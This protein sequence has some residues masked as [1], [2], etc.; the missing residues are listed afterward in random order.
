M[1][2]GP[3]DS[4]LSSPFPP[5]HLS[6]NE[7][8]TIIHKI[9]ELL[10]ESL[11]DYEQF[12]LRDR[13]TVSELEWKP[14]TK[15]HGLSAYRKRHVIPRESDSSKVH[16]VL[17]VGEIEGTVEDVMLG[18]VHASS[19]LTAVFE[20]FLY[21]SA[22][23]GCATLCS[24]IKP[25][26]DSPDRM[27]RISWDSLGSLSS[28]L[29]SVMKPRDFVM[30]MASGVTTNSTGE[31]IAYVFSHSVDV[32]N[33]PPTP[34]AIRA[35]RHFT[36]LYRQVS[37]G[38]MHLYVVGR[39]DPKGRILTRVAVRVST[40][41]ALEIAPGFISF[42]AIKKRT[43]LLN[44]Q[45]HFPRDSAVDIFPFGIPADFAT[46]PS[47]GEC[48]L[49]KK[50]ASGF[51]STGKTCSVCG[52]PACS[53]CFKSRQVIIAA[54][55]VKKNRAIKKLPFCLIC[56]QRAMELGGWDLSVAGATART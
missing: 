42:A 15:R 40:D 47:T 31:R 48:A 7:K 56:E 2:D 52:K 36:Y 33:A 54:D 45:M 16:T 3:S 51:L 29:D 27:V 10:S 14:V 20:N 53:S 30:A 21:G 39:L 13:A 26:P 50:R 4:S 17:V 19:D 43:F 35:T 37:P 49:C 38:R 32:A 55:S 22:T 44:Q 1:S 25:T 6:D 41:A 46:A 8:Q 28:T 11:A 12:L 5:L 9:D 18:S 23:I 24:I 34:Q